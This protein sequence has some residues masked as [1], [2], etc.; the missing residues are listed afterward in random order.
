LAVEKIIPPKE[1][2]HNPSLQNCRGNTV[3]LCLAYNKIIPPKEWIH[4][5]SL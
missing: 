4:N 5:P 3:A 2:I 1:W